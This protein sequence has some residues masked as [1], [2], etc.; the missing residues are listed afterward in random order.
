MPLRLELGGNRLLML[1][2]R[3]LTPLL[4]LLV[5]PALMSEALLAPTE[6]FILEMLDLSGAIISEEDLVA[7]FFFCVV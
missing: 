5:E 1:S 4:T 7:T 3:S 2:E 6:S